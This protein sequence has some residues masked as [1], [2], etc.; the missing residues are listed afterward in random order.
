MPTTKERGRGG[1]WYTVEVGRA[2]GKK[3]YPWSLI[4]FPGQILSG[5]LVRC[6]AEE[7]EVKFGFA[8]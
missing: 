8:F 2:K 7:E 6:V 3:D 4:E 5:F 1:L